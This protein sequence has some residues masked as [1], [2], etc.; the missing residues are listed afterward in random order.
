MR[1]HTRNDK[2][3]TQSTYRKYF[4]LPSI[5]ISK[6]LVNMR[7][8]EAYTDRTRGPKKVEMYPHLMRKKETDL[9]KEKVG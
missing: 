2:L 3:K 5:C 9:Y 1:L 8:L 4:V 7:A 6:Y